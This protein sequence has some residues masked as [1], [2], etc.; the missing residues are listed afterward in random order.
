MTG[1]SAAV[2]RRKV[3]QWGAAA[4]AGVCARRALPSPTGAKPAFRL[5]R[6]NQFGYDQVDLAPGPLQR[7]FEQNHA[8]LLG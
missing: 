1:N 7:Q 2:T 4:A 3:M 8:L 6:L 5:T